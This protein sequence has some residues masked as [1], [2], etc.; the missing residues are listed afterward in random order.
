MYYAKIMENDTVN[1]IEGITVS[2]FTSGCPHHCKGCFNYETWNRKYGTKISIFNLVKKLKKLIVIN[3]VERNFSVLG[4]EPLADYNIRN[5]DFIIKKIRKEYPNIIIYL[6][7]GYTLEELKNKKMYSI[8]KNV[9]YI[10][11]G[12]FIE[13]LKDKNLKMR[14][15][16]N[17]HIYKLEN[18]K[19]IDVTDKLQKNVTI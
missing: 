3:E 8:L 18:E 1:C 4:G 17:Q 2:L 14:G 6:W 15:S 16:S 12:R 19:F 10:I 7:T 5:T 13:E 11:E 9:N